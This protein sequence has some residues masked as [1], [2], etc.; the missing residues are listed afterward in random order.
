MPIGLF[1]QFIIE[2]YAKMVKQLYT[3]T[4]HETE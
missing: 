3:E 4:R 2:G 1:F